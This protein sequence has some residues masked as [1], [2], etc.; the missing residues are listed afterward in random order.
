MS[1]FGVSAWRLKCTKHLGCNGVVQYVRT[2]GGWAKEIMGEGVSQAV[3]K[4]VMNQ[5][6]LEKN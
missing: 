6:V 4:E 5:R 1:H 2:E 3:V